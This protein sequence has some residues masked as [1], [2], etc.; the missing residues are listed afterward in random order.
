MNMKLTSTRDLGPRIGRGTIINTASM[1][2]LIAPAMTIPAA[3][4]AASKHGVLGLTKAVSP[5]GKAFSFNILFSPPLLL[6]LSYPY[7]N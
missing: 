6:L 4:Y 7:R 1:Y 3:A 2:G 5:Y